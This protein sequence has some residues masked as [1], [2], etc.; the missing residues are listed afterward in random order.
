MPQENIYRKQKEVLD[1]S[2]LYKTTKRYCGT[3]GQ[4]SIDPVVFFKLISADYL[5]NMN[6]DRKI[7]NNTAMR[8]GKRQAIDR[9]YI[10]ANAS[11]DSLVGKEILDDG[12]IFTDEL[13]SNDEAVSTK[14]KEGRSLS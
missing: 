7:I 13:I 2:L 4:Q 9:A 6:S 11:M 5:E 8:F 12:N 10:K 14:Q 3:E 1:L